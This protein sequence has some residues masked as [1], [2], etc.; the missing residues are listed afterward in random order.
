MFCGLAYSAE[1][2][3]LPAGAS[4]GCAYDLG[5]R[6][7]ASGSC[8][9]RTSSDMPLG[10]I[11]MPPHCEPRSGDFAPPTVVSA[12]ESSNS[13]LPVSVII[14]VFF[15]EEIDLSTVTPKTV[16]ILEEDGGVVRDLSFYNGELLSSSYWPA[17][18][19]LP[20]RFDFPR[21]AHTYRL[22]ISGG[23]GGVSDCSGN[24]LE[25]NFEW[26]YTSPDS[27]S[28]EPSGLAAEG[29]R[30]S[31]ASGL[32]CSYYGACVGHPL[33]WGGYRDVGYGASCDVEEGDRTPLRIISVTPRGDRVPVSPELEVSIQFSKHIYRAE[34]SFGLVRVFN[35]SGRAVVPYAPPVY[36][37]ETH[38]LSYRIDRPQYNHKYRVVLNPLTADCRDNRLDTSERN[39]WSFK[40]APAPRGL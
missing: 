20:V 4:C 18:V 3:G 17:P 31:C 34:E 6:C 38:T 36:H 22:V 27:R 35:E 32:V 21:P 37:P 5:L 30:C 11:A 33:P 7:G 23:K 10:M 1:D 13:S 40:T 14:Y 8:V 28:E 26:T 12:L 29:A 39:E 15:S 24:T 25:R 9:R 2:T 19:V 16:R